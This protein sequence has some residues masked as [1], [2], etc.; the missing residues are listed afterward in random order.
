MMHQKRTGLAIGDK[1]TYG[2]ITLGDPAYTNVVV[3]Y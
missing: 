3:V 2:F 1:A